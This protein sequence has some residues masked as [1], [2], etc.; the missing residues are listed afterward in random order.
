[1]LDVWGFIALFLISSLALILS[2]I[3]WTRPAISWALRRWFFCVAVLVTLVALF[4]A[5]E[6]W[7]GKRAW[8]QTKAQ[9][10][11][12]GFNQKWEDYVPPLVPDDQNFFKAPKMQERFVGRK[13]RNAFTVPSTNE[14]TSTV[15]AATNSI[16]TEAQARDYIAWSDH[17]TPDLDLLREA[18]KRPYARMDGD[19][20]EPANVPIPNFVAAR[21]YARVLAQRAHCEFL[22]HEPDAAL[23]Q[24]TLIHDMCRMFQGAPTGKPMTLVAAMINVAVAGLYV[25]VIGE[26]FKLHAWQEPQLAALEKQLRNIELPTL[27]GEAFHHEEVFSSTILER[28]SRNVLIKLFLAPPSD[29]SSFQNGVALFLTYAPRGWFYQNMAVR[30]SLTTRYFDRVDSIKDSVSPSRQNEMTRSMETVF[31]RLSPY[32][33][34]AAINTPNF[35]RATQRMAYNQNQAN[36]ALVACALERYRLANGSYPESLDVLAP[37]YIGKLPHDII[38]GGDLKY[39]RENNTFVLYSIGWNEKDDGGTP[40]PIKSG[41]PDLDNGDWVWPYAPQH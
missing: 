13:S 27:V 21:E 15:G 32:K 7:R 17:L 23:Q 2:A 40:A 38:N 39:R 20:S 37:Q 41:Q 25:D 36:M 29:R 14:N 31:G 11:A 12:T 6:D 1:M 34:L 22:L 18:L 10:Q 26:G 19:Y 16:V 33:F 30:A 3:P 8:E 4:Y 9:L 28:S 35:S 24:L 5:E